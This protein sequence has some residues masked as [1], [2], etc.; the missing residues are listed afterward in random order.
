MMD[1]ETLDYIF[2]RTLKYISCVNAKI[3]PSF[4]IFFAYSML[5]HDGSLRR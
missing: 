1:S 3:W 5:H 2:V 4:L